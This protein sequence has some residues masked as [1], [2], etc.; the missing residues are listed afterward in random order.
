[1]ENKI[2]M[3]DISKALNLSVSTISKSLSNNSEISSK[4]KKR[5]VQYARK[6]NYIPN[7][8][9]VCFR[10]GKTKN[11]GIL[12]PNI[13]KPFYAKVLTG[14]E[15]YLESNDYKLITAISNESL[16]KEIASV[17]RMCFGNIDG[18]IICI[19][20]EALLEKQYSHINKV[21]QSG[22]PVVLFER[23]IDII[24]CDKIISKSL[25]SEQNFEKGCIQNIKR[26]YSNLNNIKS[27]KLGLH[28]AKTL[29]NRIQSSNVLNFAYK[30]YN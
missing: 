26:N 11:I 6:V 30:N 4:T 19:S 27:E 3:L 13:I 29:I 25:D 1:M 20:N 16:K 5:V 9:A 7:G 22:V 23:D 28:I 18:L 14:I 10:K 12:V 8:L 17:N 24:Y 15:Q 2:T 21:I